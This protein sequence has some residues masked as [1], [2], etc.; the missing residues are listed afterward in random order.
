MIRETSQALIT[1]IESDCNSLRNKTIESD[2]EFDNWIMTDYWLKS[3]VAYCLADCRNAIEATNL[4]IRYFLSRNTLYDYE[5]TIPYWMFH[6]GGGVITWQTI[7]EAWAANN[8]EGAG[9]TIA[10]IDR[11]R[12]LIWDKPFYVAWASKPEQQGL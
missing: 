3:N 11:M 5:F 8:F 10:F 1:E 12:Q 9:F 6:Y 2:A 7:V 4:G